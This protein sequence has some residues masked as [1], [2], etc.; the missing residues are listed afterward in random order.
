MVGQRLIVAARRLHQIDERES[1]LG[2]LAAP[3]HHLVESRPAVW[4]VDTLGAAACV[5]GHVV[6][7]QAGREL[8]LGDVDAHALAE[9]LVKC[10]L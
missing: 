4:K 9:I 10:H 3:L 5:T 2:L 8:V 6:H 1:L 7:E